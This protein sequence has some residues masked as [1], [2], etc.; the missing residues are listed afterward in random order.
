MSNSQIPPVAPFGTDLVPWARTL[1]SIDGPVESP[2]ITDDDRQRFEAIAD[3]QDRNLLA[4]FR[5][6]AQRDPDVAGEAQRIAARLGKPTKLVEL[7][8]DVARGVLLE[9][10]LRDMRLRETHPMVMQAIENP[11]FLR[12]SYDDIENLTATDSVWQSLGRAFDAGRATNERGFIG[13]RMAMGLGTEQDRTRLAEI[14]ETMRNAQRDT[15]FLAGSAEILGQMA[16]TTTA[17]LAAGG[18][19]AGLASLGGP[20]SAGAAFTWTA[21][22]AFFTQTA[23]IEGGNAYLDLIDQGVADDT[24]GSV[25][26]GIGIVNGLLEL[27]GAKVAAKPFQ[28]A[29]RQIGRRLSGGLAQ[30]TTGRA[31]ASALGEYAKALGAEVS[32]EVMQEIAN[33]TG[34]AIA[35]PE[36]APEPSW[37]EIRGR[38]GGIAFKTFQGMALLGLPGPTAHYFAQNRRAEAAIQRADAFD[39]A[40]QLA[41][42]SKVR[43]RNPEAHAAFAQRVAEEQGVQNVYVDAAV[44]RQALQATGTTDAEL[45]AQLPEVFR[46]LE[47]A[48]A[49]PEREADI[50]VPAGEWQS[51][52][53]QTKVGAALQPDIRFD[54]DGMSRREADE[55]MQE[56]SLF[57]AEARQAAQQAEADDLAFQQSASRVQDSL[58]Q[59]IRDTGRLPDAKQARGAAQ[60]YATF[61]ETQ[62]RRLGMTP[63]ALLEQFP[64]Q[65]VA[66]DV[67][68]ERAGLFNQGDVVA[69][70]GDSYQ[71]DQFNMAETGGLLWFTKS[72]DIAGA[73]ADQGGRRGVVTRATLRMDNPLDLRTAEGLR[74]LGS[75]DAMFGRAITDQNDRD[76]AARI[77]RRAR[78]AASDGMAANNFWME[79]KDAR[80]SNAWH[81]II[82]PQL[83]A[84]GFDGLVMRDAVDTG[85]SLAVFDVGQVEGVAVED[86]N[87]PNILR[88]VDVETPE[89]REWFGDSKVVDAEGRPLVVYHG[90]PDA[91]FARDPEDAV[92]RTS[93]ERFGMEDDGRAFFFTSSRATASSYADERRAFDYQSAEGGVVDVFLA[94]RNPLVINAAGAEWR[95]AQKRGKTGEVVAAAR[96]GG[97]DGLIIRSV[98][99]NYNNTSKTKPSDVFVVFEPTQ[100]KS[101]NNR[102]TWS[103]TD[104]NILRAPRGGFDPTRLAVLLYQKADFSTFVHEGA[105]FFL[106]VYS[107][108]AQTGQATQEMRDDLQTFLEWRGIDSIETWNAMS[109]DEQ[110]KAHEAFAYSFELRHFEGEQAPAGLQGLF[111]RFK[112]WLRALYR[113]VRD[114]IAAN[115]RRET[116][117]ELPILTGEVRQVMDRM[118]ASEAEVATAEAVRNMVPLFQ[119]REQSGMTDQEWAE[120]QALDE[121]KRQQAVDALDQASLRQMRWMSGSRSRI[122]KEMQ[123]QHDAVRRE[124]RKAV[125]VEV[126]QRPEFA[127]PLFIR[128]GEMVQPDG[129][130]VKVE[131]EQERKLNRAQVLRVLGFDKAPPKTKKVRGK[132]LI[133]FIRDAG[134]I[135]AE[136]WK[137]FPG[138]Q[139]RE[140]RP[141]GV[142][143]G[144][145]GGG[146]AWDYMA[147][148]ARSAGYGPQGISRDEE[149]YDWFIE[150][151]AD[152]A[153]GV[154][155]Y[156]AEDMAASG[157]ADEEAAFYERSVAPPS[158]EEMEKIVRQKVLDEMGATADRRKALA[159]FR[160]LLADEGVGIDEM[161][162]AFSV[163]S[164][165]ALVRAIQQAGDVGKAIDAATDERMLAEY[166]EL[167]DPDE[168]ERAV[169][170]ALHNE[171]R[172]RMVGVELRHLDRSVAPAR[173]MAAAAKEAARQAVAK[174]PVS[175]LLAKQFA[176][177]EVRARRKASEAVR[178]GDL[179]EATLWKRRE[180]LQGA[181]AK[182]VGE[183][184]AKIDEQVRQ[185]ARFARPDDKIAKVRDTRLVNAAR[186]I[187]SRFNLQSQTQEVSAQAAIDA[188]RNY[189]PTMYSMLEPLM[190]EAA[191]RSQDWRNLTVEQMQTLL[192]QV[193]GLWNQAKRVREIELDGRREDKATAIQ[194][195]L[196]VLAP[197]L[198]GGQKARA[199]SPG[200]KRRR[201]FGS[202]VAGMRHVESVTLQLDGG[203][204]G[205][206]HRYLFA[207]LR[208]P[209]DAYQV[210]RNRLVKQ[211]FDDTA[212]LAN[213]GGQKIDAPELGYVFSSRA[214]LIGALLHA[215]NEQNLRKNGVGREWFRRPMEEGERVDTSQWW[216]F[217]QRMLNE[218]KLT[219]ADLDFAQKV[220][221]TFESDL[222]PRAQRAWFDNYGV[223]MGEVPADAFSV[224]IDGQRVNYRGGY[225][226]A[227][228]D[229]D[230]VEPR[231]GD[232]SVDGV[233]EAG[234]AAMERYPSTSKG[235]G[236]ART[237]VYRPLLQDVRL[238]A[239]AFDQELRFIHLQRPARDLASLLNNDEVT[240]AIRE[241]DPNAMQ[242]VFMPWLE[243]TVN[244]RVMAPGGNPALNRLL[245]TLRRNVGLATMFG[246]VANA[247]QQVTGLANASAYVPRKFLRSA[248]ARY[249]SG[250]RKDMVAGIVEASQFMQLRLEQQVGQVV[251][252]ITQLTAP[253]KFG[254]AAA[255][256]QRNGYFLQR[257]MQNP[258]DVITWG[259]AHDQAI[260]E[261]KTGKQA[262]RWADSVVRRS[263]G[264]GT[265]ADISKAERAGALG[266]LFTQFSTFWFVQFNQIAQQQTLRGKA[267]TAAWLIGVNGVVAGAISQVLRGG[268]EDEDDDGAMWDDVTG[269]AFGQAASTT[270]AT[271]LPVGGPILWNLLTGERGGRINTGA[272]FSSLERSGKA[273]RAMFLD[274]PFDPE[275]DLRGQDIKDVAT[276]LSLLSGLPVSAAARPVSYGLDVALGN[277]EPAGAV[278]AVRGA[279]TGTAAPGT[280]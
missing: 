28:G 63:E 205:D 87:D 213:L 228:A 214:E 278:D 98:R 254:T 171:A 93:R 37:S 99:D 2:T 57:G 4:A 120:Y 1:P 234:R 41:A 164:G 141:S 216:R 30:E 85:E 189:D 31:F 218:G 276:L 194:R 20:V 102:G 192:A 258:V 131:T 50:V 277:V 223:Y 161:A 255:W 126:M 15:G 76:T 217:V 5:L 222:K 103:P 43:Q 264:S 227:A 75:L 45:R 26:L 74:E 113:D 86:R 157:Y 181:M 146:M 272:V 49:N 145:K 265:A 61:Y 170:R 10:Q 121:Q 125:A 123:A 24:A 58:Y 77:I 168:R 203:D 89:F 158:P 175:G 29:V 179:S 274:I 109:I 237:E 263:Q 240:A 160:G 42:A 155:L 22:A 230:W 279:I 238:A 144:N 55:W 172:Q 18:A 69:F 190:I 162:E 27:A 139:G 219:K 177:A 118:L 188:V 241:I 165:E 154:P 232:V 166:S 249:A 39:Q 261:G 148:L 82:V 153:N 243:D 34:E 186:W 197:R 206:V 130:R 242:Q 174:L 201:S 64:V 266:R 67:K 151:I 92:F 269:W 62:A 19:A 246:N 250:K 73:Y 259:A 235:F 79:T 21:G 80:A 159:P 231:Q 262:V 70:R 247:L 199:L 132:S 38:L 124:V 253:S 198:K 229:P 134:G 108:L 191:Q 183:T 110:R 106:H 12:I 256:V 35:R 111:D 169:E 271:A 11:N 268:W 65:F 136:S 6:S 211:L 52:V 90:S 212:A 147:D 267:L 275:R 140:F 84:A 137:K 270:A 184:K 138:E 9:R 220:W 226:P 54:A 135:S 94:L 128:S 56:R 68:A 91:R 114:K 204:A 100:I 33:I 260:A 40:S 149:S 16:G 53:T 236:I 51:K 143:R 224:T 23:A 32:T 107:Q 36:G 208:E 105:H 129:S 152:G 71:V 7:D 273:L 182:A 178:R 72:K 44:F 112:T 104:P 167:S 48:E 3:E 196:A 59:Q 95:E 119:T 248:A 209:F 117:E 195:I 97:H 96:A 233:T 8:L 156:R 239:R 173:V 17:A 163:D 66:Q 81:T 142:V 127:V 78:A 25:A 221:D 133:Q 14:A 202:I 252:D 122:L 60:L 88:Q 225:F 245:V 215:G 176:M 200:E 46:Q 257:A 180:L 115:Y 13:S 244:N 185:L 187:L 280:R 83:Q 251:D 193:D 47:D 101:V 116:G 210:D 207:M 150:A